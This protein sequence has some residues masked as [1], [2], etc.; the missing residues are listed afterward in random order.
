MDV[1]SKRVRSFNMSR[2]RGKDTK[3]EF[4]VRR[5]CHRNG[6]RYRLHNKALPGK[7][8]L[9]FSQYKAVIQVNGCFWHKH[10]CYLFKW[11][12]TRRDFW[13][14]KINRTAALDASNREAL[15]SDGW[16]VLT[17][18]ECAVKGKYRLA[19]EDLEAR[20]LDWLRNGIASESI[21]GFQWQEDTDPVRPTLQAAEPNSLYSPSRS[22]SSSLTGK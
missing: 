20:I 4:L 13:E 10:L 16:R 6:F 22:K 5:L 9:T 8:D 17:V 15:E 1:H 19:E 11:P 12:A 21:G 18:W 3:P 14:A 7:P 2:I